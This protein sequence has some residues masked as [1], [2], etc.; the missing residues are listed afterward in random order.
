M[1]WC[2]N[3]KNE[4]RQGIQVCT[5]CGTVLVDD[6]SD[7]TK[8]PVMFGDEELLKRMVEF[9]AYCNVSTSEIIF[10]EE[11][12]MY[13]LF[14]SGEEY[15]NAK[16]FARV[17]MKEEAEKTKTEASDTSETDYA[18]NADT[19]DVT[20]Q[21]TSTTEKNDQV[22]NVYVKA[23]EKAE[24]YKASAYALLLT[25]SVGIIIMILVMTGIIP[26]KLAQNAKY[27]SYGTMSLLFLIFLVIGFYSLKAS[28]KFSS[29]AQKENQLEQK[30]FEHFVSQ[31]TK[32][33]IDAQLQEEKQMEEV[34]DEIKYFQRTDWL[35]KQILIF[36]PDIQNA[37]LEKITDELYQKL[38]EK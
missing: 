17:F 21:E 34:P 36:A 7:E 20:D 1:P 28:K 11:A 23:E 25:G 4:Y 3:C 10:N 9:F 31:Y 30:I 2:P 14:V 26:L 16:K 27:I 29:D 13:E 32:D 15:G 24:N 37:Y 5:D 8:M 18:Q 19:M 22:S 33:T 12:R 6:L 35:K 38:F